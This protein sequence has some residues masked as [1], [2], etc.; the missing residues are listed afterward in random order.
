MEQIDASI[1]MRPLRALVAVADAR[2]FRGAAAALG[3]TQSAVSHQIAQLEAALGAPL[4]TRP[5][6]RAP[7]ALTPAGETAY[8]HAR[9]ALEAVESMGADVRAIHSERGTLRMGIFQA[10]VTDLLPATL[11][12][13]RRERPNV[14]VIL[15]EPKQHRSL[16]QALARGELDLAVTIN[17]EPDDRVEAIALLDDPWVMLTRAD[18][19]LARAPEPAFELLDGAPVIAWQAGWPN[20]AELENAWRKRGIA[21]HIIFRTDDNLALQ[22]LVAAGL[23]SACVG[24]LGAETP[25]DPGLRALTPRDVIAP[26]TVALVYPRHRRLPAAA[27]TLIELLRDRAAQLTGG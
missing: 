17:P 6:G 21:P 13:Y 10:A 19:E 23:G 27:H 18:S 25:I 15:S 20:Q 11:A 2:S 22:R 16:V 12:A 14:S 26:R 8:R 1:G 24:R 3:Y 9:R 4:L 7:T 5:G